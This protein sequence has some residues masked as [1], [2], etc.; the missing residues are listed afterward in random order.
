MMLVFV[1]A[2]FSALG[3][4]ED[5]KT[6]YFSSLG[7]PVTHQVSVPPSDGPLILIVVDALR[8]DRMSTYGAPRNTTPHLSALADDGVIFTNFFTNGNWTRPSTASLLSGVLPHEH[9]VERDSDRLADEFQTLP[10]LLA[11]A[12]MKTGAVV[13]NGN[14]GSAFGLHQG[15]QYYADTVRHWEGLP[16]ADQVLELAIPFVREHKNERFFLMLFL[17]DPHDPYHAPGEYENMFVTSPE[18]RLVRT[19]HWEL[20]RYSE[21]ERQ[22]MMAVYD[23]AVRYTDDALGRFVAELKSL[24]IYDRS[25]LVV[26]SDHG[27]AFGEHGVYLHSHHLYDELIRAPLIVRAP[28]MSRRGGF[29]PLLSQT[30][31]LLPTLVTH[32]GGKVIRPV[33][34]IDL[35]AR[36]SEPRSVDP[37]RVVISEFSNFGIRRRMA[38]TLTHKSIAQ[39]AA[40]EA[41][42]MATVGRK[43]L[44][45][46]VV[47]EGEQWAFFRVDRDP[48]EKKNLHSPAMEQA[49]IWKRLMGILRAQEKRRK[50]RDST[51]IAG[52][53]DHET[54]SDLRALGYIQ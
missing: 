5:A 44:L 25:T 18:T 21:A 3:S 47:F 36:L 37:D 49:P 15:F 29:S 1:L 26:T 2:A 52:T 45:P 9:R 32:H 39:F 16:S 20:G 43:S 40:D 24:G 28:R 33:H 50:K 14:A 12:G 35:F 13:G 17:I 27:E 42:F 10:E 48:L 23:G 31:D 8:P 19:P 7:R 38:R 30:V 51:T 34:G 54:L 4:F 11:A 46:S 6:G 22:R 41:R 53:V